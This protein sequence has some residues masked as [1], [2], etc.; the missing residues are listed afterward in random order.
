[1]VEWN[2]DLQLI[3]IPISLVAKLQRF[4]LFYNFIKNAEK[5]KQSYDYDFRHYDLIEFS[6]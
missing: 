5:G 1:M 4:H 3:F 2:E 6:I